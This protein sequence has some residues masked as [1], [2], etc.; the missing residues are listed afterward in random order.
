MPLIKAPTEATAVPTNVSTEGVVLTVTSAGG[1]VL[2]APIGPGT[3]NTGAA[4]KLITGSANITAGAG[5]TAVVIRC[6][7]NGLAGTQV[8]LSKTVTLAAGS[9]AE[10]PL[11]FLDPAPVAA[12]QSY[13][14][15]VQQ[16]GGT[17]AGTVNDIIAYTPDYS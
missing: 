13:V 7:Q 5:T 16:T 2:T 9:T 17:G 15:T 12:G 10:I 11:N 8:G 3:P 4:K 14:I 6:R 1:N